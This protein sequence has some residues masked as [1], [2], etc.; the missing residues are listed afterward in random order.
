[1]ASITSSYLKQPDVQ[2]LRPRNGFCPSPYQCIAAKK[3]RKKERNK[4]RTN[5]RTKEI[6]KERKKERKKE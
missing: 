6:K 4:E 1:V 3:E 2:F 5:E